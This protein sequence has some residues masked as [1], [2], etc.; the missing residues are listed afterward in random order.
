[1][2]AVDG[3]PIANSSE[4]RSIVGAAVNAKIFD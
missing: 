1:V 3:Q 4:F 2:L